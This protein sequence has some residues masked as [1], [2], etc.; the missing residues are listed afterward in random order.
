M[1]VAYDNEMYIIPTEYTMFVITSYYELL[2]K[3]HKF[4]TKI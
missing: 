1:F 4:G 3:E 2:Y